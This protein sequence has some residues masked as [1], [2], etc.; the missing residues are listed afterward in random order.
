MRSHEIQIFLE[1]VN[2]RQIVIVSPAKT[3]HKHFAQV[4]RSSSAQMAG[5]RPHW[6]LSG[7]FLS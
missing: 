6:L 4:D 3:F 7:R 2:E 1:E 5:L